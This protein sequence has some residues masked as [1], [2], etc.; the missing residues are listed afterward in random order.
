M[1]PYQ[2]SLLFR[3]LRELPDVEDHMSAAVDGM[4]GYSAAIGMECLMEIDKTTDK[5]DLL[6]ADIAQYHSEVRD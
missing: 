4:M 1:T 2:E 3:G 5:A 6:E